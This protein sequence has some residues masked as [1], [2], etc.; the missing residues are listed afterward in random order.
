MKHIIV[1][2]FL[3]ISTYVSFKSGQSFSRL[4]ANKQEGKTVTMRAKSCFATFPGIPLTGRGVIECE[5][6][7]PARRVT[8]LLREAVNLSDQLTPTMTPFQYF[9]NN[10]IIRARR[11]DLYGDSR[12]ALC[13]SKAATKERSAN[14]RGRDHDFGKDNISARIKVENNGVTCRQ[15]SPYF[16]RISWGIPILMVPGC[17]HYIKMWKNS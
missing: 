17:I 5:S 2:K 11:F 16:Y 10:K 13:C 9:Y 14:K 3:K 1:T 12:L 15:K 7:R 4:L 8:I 6:V